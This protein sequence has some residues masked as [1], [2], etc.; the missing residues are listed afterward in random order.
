MNIFM[1]LGLLINAGCIVVNRFVCEL[2]GMIAVPVY[3]A[4]VGCFIAGMV[5]RQRSGAN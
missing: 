4:G 5:I 2:P 3:L 1:A